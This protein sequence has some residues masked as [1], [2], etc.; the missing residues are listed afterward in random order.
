MSHAIQVLLPIALI[1][2]LG[3]ALAKWRFLGPD[4]MADLN[5]LTFYVA[6]PALIVRSIAEV[7][8]PVGEAMKLYG[9]L[10]AA[11][12]LGAIGTWILAWLLGVRKSAW[13]SVAQASFRGNLAYAGL[14]VL[15]YFAAG[16][17]VPARDHLLGT[18]LLVFGPL[19]ASYNLI[20]VVL[21]SVGAGTA[22][23]W[24]RI[25]RDI[26]LNPLILACLTGF[27]L[28][29]LQWPLPPV[30][31]RAM[32]ALGGVALPVALLCIGGSFVGN[33]PDGTRRGVLLAVVGKILLLPV[34]ALLGCWI[35][36]LEGD[37]RLIVLVFAGTPTAATAY[38]MV[39]QMRGDPELTA[40]A[41]VLSTLLAFASL[42]LILSF[43]L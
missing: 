33:R 4:F 10:L 26:I 19:T 15:T 32:G 40:S 5:R 2:L 36:G 34:L 17:E 31:D 9:V 21:L 16:W 11:T 6:L 12:L 1:I 35:F 28:A 20:A 14:P 43:A 8:V 13:G 23:S 3:W 22:I 18:A 24:P 37:Q 27:L 25:A 41:I 29:L 38:T 39:T 42:A 30:I 7:R